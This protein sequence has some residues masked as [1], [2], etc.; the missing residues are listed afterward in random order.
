[1]FLS[2]DIFG[3]CLFK[4]RVK[5][6]WMCFESVTL[7]KNYY[8]YQPFSQTKVRNNFIKYVLNQ[9]K[10]KKLIENWHPKKSSVCDENRAVRKLAAICS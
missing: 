8:Y 6:K 10:K 5:Q 2:L 9:E 1:M 7:Q 3:V 4:I